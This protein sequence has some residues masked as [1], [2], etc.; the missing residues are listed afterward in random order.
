M[1]TTTVVPAQQHSA[2]ENSPAIWCSECFALV[3]TFVWVG[4][5]GLCPKCAKALKPKQRRDAV[6]AGRCSMC[7]RVEEISGGLCKECR[8]L[9]S[10][11]GKMLS[12]LRQLDP[13]VYG[14]LRAI[15]IRELLLR[16]S[17]DA[18]DLESWRRTRI[19]RMVARHR[20][21]PS[22]RCNRCRHQR[23]MLDEVTLWTGSAE[24]YP[25]R[26]PCL[27]CP[28]GQDSGSFRWKNFEPRL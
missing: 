9:R 8:D 2:Q 11:P 6:Q 13:D 25:A 21:D 16:L 26:H 24:A 27:T 5:R 3:Q 7:F 15:E 10:L 17:D 23:P 1:A 20:M 14:G 22:N 18:F 4:R 28:L 19:R 12:R